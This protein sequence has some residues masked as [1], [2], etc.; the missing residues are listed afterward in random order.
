MIRRYRMQRGELFKLEWQDIDF[1]RG[2]INIR[3]PK[4]GK[5]RYRRES[6]RVG[7]SIL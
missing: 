1:E 4:G 7:S 6:G 5:S 3:H 2:F